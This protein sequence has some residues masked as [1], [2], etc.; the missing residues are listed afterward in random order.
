MK[1]KEVRLS[2]KIIFFLILLL[3]ILLRLVKL[4]LAPAG[5]NQDEALA[6]Y[7]SY[8]LL[9][10]G[11]DSWGY[12][13]PVYLAAWGSGMNALESYL[14][15]P[16]IALFGLQ[17]WAIRLPQALVAILSI[18]CFYFLLKELF[19]E[20]MALIG[21][22]VLTITPWHIMLSRWGLES[23][24]APGFLLFGMYF[25]VLAYKDHR[26][27]L[28]AA[29][30]YGLSLYAYALLWIAVPLILLF[31]GLYLIYKKALKPDIWLLVSVLLLFLIALPLILFLL[32]NNGY[33]DEIRTGFISIPRLKHMRGNEI[34]LSQIPANLKALFQTV[35]LQNDELIHNSTKAGLY[36]W[37]GLPMAVVGIVFYLRDGRHAA[38]IKSDAEDEGVI[39]AKNLD[40]SVLFMIQLIVSLILGMLTSVNV[41][42]INVIHLPIIFFECYGIYRLCEHFAKKKVIKKL[43][44]LVYAASFLVF[45]VYYFTNYQVAISYSFNAGA[46][47]AIRYAASTGKD[48]YVSDL[49]SYSKVLYATEYPVDK[50][51]ETVYRLDTAED[52]NRIVK[53]FEGFTLGVAEVNT[54]VPGAYVMRIYG[55]PDEILENY[56]VYYTDGHFVCVIV[57]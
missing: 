34:S 38:H 51:M 36:H 22:A 49:I 55:L 5:V 21:M 4:G 46:E 13:N 33:I 42:R 9:H 20:K 1:I 43:V 8:S 31:Y 27:Y 35:V 52:D 19:D 39:T 50:F 26:F 56:P 10:F 25:L 37:I 40:L 32:V 28:L 30:F 3:A 7:E 18:V 23:N 2:N 11:V 12:H 29:L 14:M 45:G 57:E 16:F 47:E 41:N 44:A 48:V 15:M 54:S 17:T 24:L 6:A 53:S